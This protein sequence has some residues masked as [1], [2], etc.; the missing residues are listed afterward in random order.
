MGII[1]LRKS[2]NFRAREDIVMQVMLSLH[3]IPESR[4]VCCAVF[5]GSTC[6][7]TFLTALI[8][9]IITTCNCENIR[10]EYVSSLF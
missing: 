5:N 3:T 4:V 6:T 1:E 10:D 9:A 8:I 7:Q 2:L